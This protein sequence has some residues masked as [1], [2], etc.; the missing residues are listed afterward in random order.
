MG[1][2]HG[3]AQNPTLRGKLWSLMMNAANLFSAVKH[4]KNSIHRANTNARIS[5]IQSTVLHQ[6]CHR[7]KQQSLQFIACSALI[8]HTNTRFW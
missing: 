7:Q 2:F 3:S 8:I 6:L 1:T 4:D 5:H